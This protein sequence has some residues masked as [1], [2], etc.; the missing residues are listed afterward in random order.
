MGGTTLNRVCFNAKQTLLC[1]KLDSTF[2]PKRLYFQTKQTLLAQNEP[3]G[4]VK[5]PQYS[6]VIFLEP[7]GK[8]KNLVNYSDNFGMKRSLLG[9]DFGSNFDRFCTFSHSELLVSLLHDDVDNDGCTHNWGDRIQGNDA[10]RAGKYADDVAQQGD[11]CSGE[12]GGRHQ[13]MVVV[14]N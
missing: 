7:F 8:H 3:S 2:R 10:Q 13:V 12:D 6:L 5:H 4:C 11:G 9:I 14:C 1:F